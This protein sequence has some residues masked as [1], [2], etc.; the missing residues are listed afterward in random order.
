MEDGGGGGA[1]NKTFYSCFSVS[2]GHG[3]SGN[4][5]D[6]CEDGRAVNDR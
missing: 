6:G 5:S 3:L 1:V 2:L 4:V